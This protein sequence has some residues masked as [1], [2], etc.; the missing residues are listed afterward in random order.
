MKNEY[1]KETLLNIMKSYLVM[2]ERDGEKYPGAVLSDIKASMRF[3]LRQ[4]NRDDAISVPRIRELQSKKEYDF[5]CNMS[6]EF[7][8]YDAYEEWGCASVWLGNNI[9]AEYNFCVEDDGTNLSAIY[10]VELNPTTNCM[11]TDGSTFIPCTIDF[12]NPNWKTALEV[13]MCQALI[14][15]FDL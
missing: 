13:S 2:I 9:G 3:V 10:K 11:E 6:E 5:E 8:K 14:Q 12:A 7:A 15:F 4:A 1:N